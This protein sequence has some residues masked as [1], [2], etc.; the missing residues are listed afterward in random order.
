[1]AS[2][3]TVGSGRLKSATRRAREVGEMVGLLEDVEQVDRAVARDDLGLEIPQPTIMAIAR[4]A[5]VTRQPRAS[6]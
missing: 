1:M 4:Q 3:P 6:A 2:N 5:G